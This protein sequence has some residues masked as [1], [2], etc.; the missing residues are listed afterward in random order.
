MDPSID[1]YRSV[2]AND[3]ERCLELNKHRLSPA[4]AITTLL[5]P[6]FGQR[7]IIVGSGMMTDTD[8][9]YHNAKEIVLQATQ[10]ILDSK[11]TAI[12]V[13]VSSDDG[14]AHPLDEMIDHVDNEHYHQA[15]KE[16]AKFEMFK[17]RA[18]LPELEFTK[19]L[20]NVTADGVVVEIG[21]ES[22]KTRGK[23]LPKPSGRN[24]ADYVQSNG[25]FDLLSFF[26]H[27]KGLFLCLNILIQREASCR[28]VEV[29]CE[30]FFLL[31]IIIIFRRSA[32]LILM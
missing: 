8:T 2:Y 16:F 27:H 5:N 19:S 22:V 20:K 28:V 1:Q 14:S 26:N 25:R 11:D 32:A 13:E 21:E 7:P 6:V 17:M 23:N 10:D 29:G 24:L 15:Q 3:L 18:F 31:Q 4:F 30:R 9:Q 12:I